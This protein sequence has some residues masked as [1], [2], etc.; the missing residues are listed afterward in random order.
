M[1]SHGSSSSSSLEVESYKASEVN[2]ESK[3]SQ[4]EENSQVINAELFINGVEEVRSQYDYIFQGRSILPLET[5]IEDA[6]TEVTQSSKVCCRTFLCCFRS[7]NKNIENARNKVIKLASVQFD[8]KQSFH[9]NVILTWYHEVTGRD[10]FKQEHNIWQKMGFFNDDTKTNGL[11]EAGIVLVLLHLL[12]M[13]RKFSRVMDLF[14]TCCLNPNASGCLVNASLTIMKNVKERF[15]SSEGLAY[16][17]KSTVPALVTF[18]LIQTGLIALFCESFEQA[19]TKSNFESILKASKS[20]TK[21][22]QE[23]VDLALSY[24]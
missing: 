21:S 1:S 15:A 13:K 17:S 12:F 20:R 7:K 11:G 4:S 22:I 3:H 10:S 18:F 6:D 23:L 5:L 9:G 24:N 19:Q 8:N 2:L 14:L 16:I